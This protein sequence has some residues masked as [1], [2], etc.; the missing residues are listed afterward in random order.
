MLI[1]RRC[2]H[3]VQ[4]IKCSTGG[5]GLVDTEKLN[6]WAQTLPAVIQAHLQSRASFYSSFHLFCF[7]QRTQA[8][9]LCLSVCHHNSQDHMTSS[10]RSIYVYPVASSIDITTILCKRT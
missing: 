6:R 9:S 8:L 1:H 3:Q 7:S 5:V 4:E 2:C 10:D